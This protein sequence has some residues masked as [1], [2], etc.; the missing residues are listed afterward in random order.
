MPHS[1]AKKINA[2]F[3][4]IDAKTIRDEQKKSKLKEL[5]IEPSDESAMPVLGIQPKEWR[6]GP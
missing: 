1:V 6:S 2:K 3:F 4:L 5:K